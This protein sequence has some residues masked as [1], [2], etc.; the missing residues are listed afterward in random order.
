[1][2]SKLTL[3]VC[4][5]FLLLPAAWS[6]SAGTPSASP[7]PSSSAPGE[8]TFGQYRVHQSI[9][10]GYRVSDVTGSG[11]MFDTLVNEH[12]G[13]R[14]FE[15]TLSM[16]SDTAAGQPFDD[17]F[18]NSV[19]WG[20]DPNNFLRVR[21]GKNQWYDFRASFRRDQNFSASLLVILSEE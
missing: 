16:R 20:G 19:G 10:A 2:T 8:I 11:G 18:V 12:A 1:M 7:S 13:L 17:L 14:L 5:L 6:Q 9:E 15:Q 4:A 21:V 3:C